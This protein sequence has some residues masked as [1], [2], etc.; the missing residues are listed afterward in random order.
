MMNLISYILKKDEIN[1]DQPQEFNMNLIWPTILKISQK[2]F[3]NMLKLG[4]KQEE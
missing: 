4:W 1:W 3:G 2:H